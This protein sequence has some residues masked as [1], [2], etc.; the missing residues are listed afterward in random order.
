VE[1]DDVPVAVLGLAVDAAIDKHLAYVGSC[2]AYTPALFPVTHV[3]AADPM[4]TRQALAQAGSA[5][6]GVT[7]GSVEDMKRLRAGLDRFR[8]QPYTVGAS[9][10]MVDALL[11]VEQGVGAALRQFLADSAAA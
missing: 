10:A 1:L 5:A 4:Q 11:G 6:E 7:I 3:F 9:L 8:G 2:S